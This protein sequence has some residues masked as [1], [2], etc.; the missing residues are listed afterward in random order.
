MNCVNLLPGASAIYRWQGALERA[1]ETWMWMETHHT[2]LDPCLNALEALH[3]YD[4]PKVLVVRPTDVADAYA[5]WVCGEVSPPETA[6]PDA[7]V[8]PDV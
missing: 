1:R 5:A 4:V 7:P 8:A 2:R 3:P 6:S